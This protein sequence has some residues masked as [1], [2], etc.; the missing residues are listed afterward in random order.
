MKQF[1]EAGRIVREQTP[2]RP[3]VSHPGFAGRIGIACENITPPVEIYSRNWGAA[4]HD[5]AESIHDLLSLTAISFSSEEH[6][7]PL[8]LLDFDLGWWRSESMFQ[9]FQR[10]LLEELSLKSSELIIAFSHTHA[11]PAFVDEDPSLPGSE[12]VEEYLQRI[13]QKAIDT[14]RLAIKNETEAILDWHTGRCDLASNRDFTDPTTNANRII[15]GYN[16][17]GVADDTLLV[18]RVTNRQGTVIATLVNYACHPTTLAWENRTISPDYIGAMRETIE[19][20]IDAPA[21]FLQ[22]ASG[23]L[24]PRYQYVGDTAVADRYGRQLGYSALAT[25]EAMEPPATKLV[26]DSV[27][28][29]G[30]PLAVWR[31]QKAVPSKQLQACE[32]SIELPLKD[33]PTTEELEEQQRTCEDRTLQERIRRKLAIRRGV[34]DGQ[35]YSLPVYVWQLG[36]VILIGSKAEAYSVLQT[37]LRRHFPQ[38]TLVCMNLIN[39]SIGYLAPRE[40]YEKNVYQVWQT[41]FASGSLE[42]TIKGMKQII[43]QVLETSGS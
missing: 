6:P 42:E 28:E 3:E 16:P 32:S 12:L 30:A 33:W 23:E 38:Q 39:G 20:A 29:S 18:G 15:C 10:K 9:S 35:T 8:V 24:S 17:Y 25:L 40:L 4:K 31:H 21:L 13:L 41:P 22:G 5:Q 1:K 37:E 14:A 2:G 34:G 26:F 7:R 11:G 19:M 36:D 27:M 43:S